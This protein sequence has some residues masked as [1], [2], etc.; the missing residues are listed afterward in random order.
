MLSKK[1]YLYISQKDHL[2]SLYCAVV[3]FTIQSMHTVIINHSGLRYCTKF[4][5]A[6]SSCG[7][8]GSSQNLTFLW[9]FTVASIK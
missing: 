6:V 7:Y 3:Q 5:N 8:M 1:D 9:P 4:V 2:H